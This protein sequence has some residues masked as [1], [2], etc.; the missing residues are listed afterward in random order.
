MTTNR[1]ILVSCPLIQDGIHS[2]REV[3]EEH[4]ITYDV[5]EIDQQLTEAELLDIIE[6]YHGVIAGDDEFT[7]EV[8]ANADNLQVVSKWGIGVDN[9]DFEAA[10]DHN[11]VVHNTPGAF[12]DEVADVVTGYAIM[13]TR[14]LHSIDSGVRRGEWPCPR[15]DSLQTR[16][17]G[18]L[19]V[20]NI[21]SEVARRAAGHKMDVIGHDVKPLPDELREEIGIE[22]VTVDELFER[23]DIVSLNC[24]LTPE[25]KNVV[26]QERLHALGEDGYL[27]NTARGGLVDESALVTALRNNKIAGAA[28]DVYEKEPIGPDNPLTEFENVVLGTHNAQNTVEA[29]ESVNDRAVE[30]LLSELR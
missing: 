9:I 12:A 29:V 22:S 26:D 28:L 11:V 30:N 19:G 24:A 17:F 3:L 7:R 23:S 27:I 10:A 18:V 5:P 2:Y 4:G 14:Q 20:G 8:F 13:L 15:G 25:T 16:T 6:P 21:G 1:R